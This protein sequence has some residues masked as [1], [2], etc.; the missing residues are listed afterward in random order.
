MWLW[1]PRLLGLRVHCRPSQR[2]SFSSLYVAFAV[3]K[4]QAWAD[5]NSI[6]NLEELLDAAGQAT[7]KPVHKAHQLQAFLQGNGRADLAR[8][9]QRLARAR[10]VA[11]HPDVGLAREVASCL[12]SADVSEQEGPDDRSELA[13]AQALMDHA[14]HHPEAL[15]LQI[16]WL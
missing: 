1:S 9:V 11:A 7:G 4:G 5:G 8:R 16:L 10:H 14:E 6:D 13:E 12:H 2:R 15:M 3:D